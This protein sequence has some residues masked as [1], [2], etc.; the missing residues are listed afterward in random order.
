[1]QWP[2]RFFKRRP[3]THK[4]DYGHVLICAGSRRM[5]GAAL[6]CAQA[7]MRAGAGY[8]TLAVPDALHKIFAAAVREAVTLPLLSTPEMSV[9]E[10][11]VFQIRPFLEKAQVLVLGCGM[12]QN[13]STQKFIR[14][15]LKSAR[16]PLVLDADGLNAL[17]GHMSLLK[18]R[19][20]PTVL[21]PHPK[22]MARL[23]GKG[24]TEIQSSRKNIAKDFCLRYNSTLILKGHRT[25][26]CE[27]DRVYENATG[28]PGMA[29]AGTG[30]VLSGIIGAFV[31]Q[32]MPVY[33]AACRAVYIHGL[34]GDLA[35][36]DKT[37]PGLVASDLIEYLP[38]ALNFVRTHRTFLP[39]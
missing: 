20:A 9:S 21:T 17:A 28:N 6:L 16:I 38:K 27:K 30:D 3:G 1:M 10:E 8:V 7:A 12:S 36:K 32:G 19:M 4:G 34:S 22:E 25:L 13:P 29:S 15:L 26:V 11:A 5:T 39:K 37:Q 35:A 2:V 23:T 31:G 18:G 24:T 33:D 14:S